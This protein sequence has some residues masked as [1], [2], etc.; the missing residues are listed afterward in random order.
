MNLCEFEASLVYTVNSRTVPVSS[1]SSSRSSS[2]SSSNNNNDNNP[3]K[4]LKA[5]IIPRAGNVAWRWVTYRRLH[6][7]Y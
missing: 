5:R 7:Q 6:P 3:T 2:S 1:K 4:K